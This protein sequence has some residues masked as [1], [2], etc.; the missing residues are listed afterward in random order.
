MAIQL[1]EPE[2]TGG[3][4]DTVVLPYKETTAG[5]V[6]LDYQRHLPGLGKEVLVQPGVVMREADPHAGVGVI[7]ANDLLPFMMRV[8]LIVNSHQGILGKGQVDAAL[9]GMAGREGML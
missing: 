2:I 5:R 4:E 8:N 9:T 7:P 1:V 6:R 3:G